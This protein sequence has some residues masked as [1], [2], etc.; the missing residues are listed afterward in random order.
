MVE[1]PKYRNKW[2]LDGIRN[3]KRQFRIPKAVETKT[4]IRSCEKSFRYDL[5]GAIRP[6]LGRHRWT[7]H[8]LDDNESIV[9]V[10]FVVFE[11]RQV[12]LV[13]NRMRQIPDCSLTHTR[14]HCSRESFRFISFSTLVQIKCLQRAIFTFFCHNLNAERIE[15][16]SRPSLKI[17]AQLHFS[18][19]F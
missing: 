10:S 13:S 3:G 16:G 1:H 12:Q 18:V 7:W 15:I 14:S 19:R 17:D 4:D 2:L 11:C 9:R 5:I 8:R 6:E